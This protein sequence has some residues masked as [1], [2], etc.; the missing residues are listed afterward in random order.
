MPPDLVDIELKEQTKKS[1]KQFEYFMSPGQQKRLKYACSMLQILSK[2]LTATNWKFKKQFNYRLAFITVTLP[3]LNNNI[4][5]SDMKNIYF[6]NFL[7]IL[8]SKYGLRHYVWKAEAQKNG[9]IHFHLIANIYIHFAIL[10][11][12]WNKCIRKTGLVQEFNLKFGYND[13]N[14]TDIH[15]VKKIKHLGS[16]LIKYMS[17]KDKDKRE[18]SGKLWNCSESLKFTKR[19]CISGVETANYHSNYLYSYF[20]SS[21]KKTQYCDLLFKNLYSLPHKENLLFKSLLN[22]HL[23]ELDKLALERNQIDQLELIE[24]L[25]LIR[26]KQKLKSKWSIMKNKRKSIKT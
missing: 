8:R 22:L 1:K 2:E 9:N 20:F 5:D 11:Y 18:I 7:N 21:I 10:R 13:P 15:S 19:L 17:K 16:Y 23:Y 26:I 14:S 3:A 25:T 4:S 24:K 6:K 12:E